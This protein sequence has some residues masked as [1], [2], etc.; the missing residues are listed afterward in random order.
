VWTEKFPKEAPR[1]H[2]NWQLG[3][4]AYRWNV[5]SRTAKDEIKQDAA[6]QARAKALREKEGDYYLRI[7]ELKT[8]KTLGRLLVETG[9]GSFRITNVLAVGDHVVLADS[10]NRVLVYSLSSGERKARVFG[11][12]PEAAIDGS[13]L[14]VEAGRGQL[15]VYDLGSM[16]KSCE[17][18][19]PREL[20]L[21]QF[22]PDGR[23]LL[24]LTN[25]QRLYSVDL[26]AAAQ[27][28]TAKSV[29]SN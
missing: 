2:F 12:R 5:S 29:P 24:A 3:T 27:A 7:V 28:A 15:V 26:S 10:Q 19:F 9:K 16:N 22:T 1:V 20:S 6:L 17:F 21:V 23:S 25:T 11:R 14:A 18:V 4:V 8:G 13:R